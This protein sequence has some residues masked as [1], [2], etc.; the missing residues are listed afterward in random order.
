M[1]KH[2][3]IKLISMMLFI[4]SI[5]VYGVTFPNKP[6]S[7]H[8]YVDEAGLIDELTGPKVDAIASLLLE[9]ERVPLFVVTIPNLTHYGATSGGIERYTRS[10]FDR[11]GIGWKDRNYGV[12]LL[13]SRGD[14][15]ARIELG[16]DWKGQH[17]AQAKLIMDEL[18]VPAFKRGDYANGILDGVRGLD[19]M[20]RGLALPKPSP[21]VWFW[22][23][24]IGAALF[25]VM[26]IVS[27]FRSGRDGWAWALIVAT[28]ILILFAFR[29]ISLLPGSGSG[30]G[31][32]GGFGGGGGATGSW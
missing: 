28:G 4:T 3:L 29:I 22:P 9:Q 30:G 24:I 23:A 8:F 19:A 7:E 12:L 27:L 16:A 15:K 25:L 31:F 17:D 21:P 5:S 1:N 6:E 20:A 32:G 11:W 10:L 18:I 13:I 14:R 2:L 26:L